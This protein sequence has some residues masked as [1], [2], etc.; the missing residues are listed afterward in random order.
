MRLARLDG[1]GRVPVTTST[2][3]T[4]TAA[5]AR[6]R[7]QAKR[8]R[9]V[10]GEKEDSEDLEEDDDD[11]G[12]S[13]LSL[14]EWYVF[15]G[16]LIVMG[17]HRVPE[18]R[19]YWSK[20]SDVGVKAVRQAMPYRRFEQIWKAFHY[21]NQPPYARMGSR[22]RCASRL[23][24]IERE[25]D[26]MVKVR[27]LCSMVN[28]QFRRCRNPARELC[29]DESMTAF[30]GRSKV[31]VSRRRIDGDVDRP[32]YLL[33]YLRFCFDDRYTNLESPRS[34]DSNSSRCASRQRVTCWTTS[35]T[36]ERRKRT[37]RSNRTT[38]RCHR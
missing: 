26:A 36:W 11:D 18:M 14:S 23:R 4:Q 19:Q 9:C 33:T 25:K 29:V 16:V 12:W 10:D 28:R 13:P 5:P 2:V 32:T 31:K 37:W 34:G 38:S 17:Y 30:T 1:K 20:C 6:R 35:T 7:R 21:S 24:A 3:G 22:A 27:F 15:V 8:K